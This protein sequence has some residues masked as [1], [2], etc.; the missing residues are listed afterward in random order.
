MIHVLT[1]PLLDQGLLDEVLD[2]QA[3]EAR[4]LV[5]WAQTADVFHTHVSDDYI[6]WMARN[7]STT[8]CRVWGCKRYG[9]DFADVNELRDHCVMAHEVSL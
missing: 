1:D 9:H 2:V 6:D 8:A 7:D 3:R 5:I 4:A